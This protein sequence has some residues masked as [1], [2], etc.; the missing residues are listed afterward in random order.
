MNVQKVINRDKVAESIH[1]ILDEGV[2]LIQKE[3]LT[4]NDHAKLKVIR[5]MGGTIN[6][7]VSMIQQ[8]TAMIR[9]SI[10]VER[11]KQ[12]GYGNLPKELE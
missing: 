2:K 3:N 9:A 12:L 11:M 10:V 7:A 5:T 4:Q 6:A 1:S 8:E